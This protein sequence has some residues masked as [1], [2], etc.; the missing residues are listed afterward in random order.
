MNEEEIT[1][2]LLGKNDNNDIKLP[3]C[4]KCKSKNTKTWER[5]LRGA[6]EMT[7]IF[8]QCQDCHHTMIYN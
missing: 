4:E 7:S 8:V 5:Q 6:D 3:I 1:R 2:I